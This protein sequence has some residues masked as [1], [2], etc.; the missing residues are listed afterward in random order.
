LGL[1]AARWGNGR[2]IVPDLGS[3]DQFAEN[4]ILAHN[5]DF[6][7]IPRFLKQ[8]GKRSRAQSSS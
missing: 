4:A 1:A 5:H 3:R 6:F 8:I 2:F 7:P